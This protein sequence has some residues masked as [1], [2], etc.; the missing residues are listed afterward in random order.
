MQKRAWAKAVG[1]ALI[2]ALGLI[3]CVHQGVARGCAAGNVCDDFETYAVGAAP[4][5]RWLTQLDQ[6]EAIVDSTRAFSGNHSVRIT[7]GGHRTAFIA[8]EGAPLFPVANDNL[9]GRMMVFLEAAPQTNVHWTLIEAQGRIAETNDLAELR[10]GGQHPITSNGAFVGSQLMANYE[11]PEWYATGHGP[12]T[13]CW[14][15]ADE[16]VVMPT[17]RWVCVAWQFDGAHDRMRFSLDGQPISSLNV[18]GVGE[19]CVHQPAS[20]PWRSPVFNRLNLG[21]ASYQDDGDR[22]VWIDDVAVG[23]TPQPCPSPHS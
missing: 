10:Y 8:L 16:S 23:S 11:T 4:G 15:H 3:A 13:D 12:K 18:D 7:S 1:G 6:G 20:Y 19:G 22:H 17:G 14:H 2:F 5:G 21:W 9:Y